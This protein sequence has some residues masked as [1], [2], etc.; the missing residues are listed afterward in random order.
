MARLALIALVIALTTL[1]AFA[2]NLK[3][4]QYTGTAGGNG[5]REFVGPY[6][7]D[8]ATITAIQVNSGRRVDGIR[9]SYRTADGKSHTIRYGSVGGN[10][11]NAVTVNE[12]VHLVGIS[13]RAGDQIDAIRFHFSDGTRSEMFGGGGGN[14]FTIML[15]QKDGRY[16]GRAVGFFGRYGKVIDKIGIAYILD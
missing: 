2:D 10:A 14:E 11:Q 4:V 13:G 6:V 8:D 1:S 9:F 3:Q 5:G 15:P 16:V 12:G 7:P